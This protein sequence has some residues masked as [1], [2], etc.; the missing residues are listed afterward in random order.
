[1]PWR[2]TMPENEKARWHMHA[3]MVEE[4]G[5]CQRSHSAFGM[6]LGHTR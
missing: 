1:M 4:I 6:P 5:A 3:A 2:T